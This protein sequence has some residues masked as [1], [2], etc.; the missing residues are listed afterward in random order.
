MREDFDAHGEEAFD[1]M[2]CICDGRGVVRLGEDDDIGA[3]KP[4]GMVDFAEDRVKELSVG[5][6]DEDDACVVESLAE[7]FDVVAQSEAEHED[8][9]G[10][11][12]IER[13][14]KALGF[15]EWFAF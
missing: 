2:G 9:A 10:F 14:S 11:F 15:G 12:Q 5:L 4:G 13:V 8:A 1:A 3:G 7:G 6:E